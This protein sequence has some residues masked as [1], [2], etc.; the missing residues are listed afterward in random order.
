MYKMFL[1]NFIFSNWQ[2]LV[3]FRVWNAQKMFKTAPNVSVC[4]ESSL[5]A[6]NVFKAT[7]MK[8][9]QTAPVTTIYYDV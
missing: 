8:D 6:V 7:M 3:N 4:T 2:K 5:Q 9:I 1:I